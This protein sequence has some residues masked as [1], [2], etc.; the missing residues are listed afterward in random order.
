V[1][2]PIWLAEAARVP[3]GLRRR[4]LLELIALVAV[5][6]ACK[7]H[8]DAPAPA[9]APAAPPTAL[10]RAAYRTLGAAVARILPADGDF[11]GAEET[12]VITFIDRE[13]AIAPLSRIAPLVIGFA[14]ALDAAAQQ[15]AHVAF[16]GAQWAVQDAILDDAAHGKLGSQL[17][18]AAVFRIL[19]GL[20]L[21]GFL[22]DP[23]H[24]GNTDQRGWKAIGFAAPHLR[25]P[26]GSH[27]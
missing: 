3:V 15:R 26:G 16:A 10:D 27:G 2:L 18:E 7:E 9:P 13:L 5:L 14:A 19:H 4:E 6:P 11:P 12:G 21:E 17:P 25:T 1:G 22:G 8:H 20:V 23:L 24:G